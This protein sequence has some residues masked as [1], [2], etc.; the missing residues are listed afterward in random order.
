[1]LLPPM[2]QG[3][4]NRICHQAPG[5]QVLKLQTLPRH[6]VP[7]SFCHFRRFRLLGRNLKA[8]L[9]QHLP[10]DIEVQILME[11]VVH[12]DRLSD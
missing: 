10:A 3:D 8:L 12:R 2:Y 1:M 6:A 7:V 11:A 9:H 5:V 4:N